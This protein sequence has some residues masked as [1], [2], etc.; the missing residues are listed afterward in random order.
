MIRE[1]EIKRAVIRDLIAQ[2]F[3]RA[4]PTSE[5]IEKI[6]LQCED[7]VTI[8]IDQIQREFQK[9]RFNSIAQELIAAGCHNRLLREIF[10]VSLRK[11]SQYRTE[12]GI[13]SPGRARRLRKNETRKLDET[14]TATA[15]HDW[16]DKY[17]V[18]LWC[19]SAHKRHGLPFVSIYR[20]MTDQYG[21]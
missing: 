6:I 5:Q 8:D 10:G 17:E 13:P 1:E 2:R 7:C 21:A 12:E 9:I 11:I 3:S 14:Y 20:Y 15:I 19:L 18:A 16:C 4:L